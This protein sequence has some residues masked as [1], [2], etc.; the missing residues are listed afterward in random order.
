ML[1]FDYI[2]ENPKQSIASL[3]FLFFLVFCILDITAYFKIKAGKANKQY[4]HKF[5][6]NIRFYAN[7]FYILCVIFFFGITCFYSNFNCLLL[8][9]A[10]RN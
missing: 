3:V 5:W 4:A 1:N 8:F 7:I 6:Y 2:K 9:L 10:F